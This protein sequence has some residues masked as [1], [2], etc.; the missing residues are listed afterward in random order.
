MMKQL[1]TLLMMLVLLAFTAPGQ[2]TDRAQ[3]VDT[4]PV[5]TFLQSPG[6]DPEAT[7]IY[8]YD[9]NSGKAIA[10]HNASKPLVPASVM[11]CVTTASLLDRAGRKWRYETPVYITGN[12]RKGVLDG[13][14]L[15]EASADPSV[16]TR[17]DPG[18]DNI[19]DE[20]VQALRQ[21]HIDT[22]RGSIV[23]DEHRFAGPAINP[24]WASGDLPNAYG[25]GTHGFNFE[26]NASGNASVRD[27]GA[28]FRSRLTDALKA[29]GIT[30]LG[31]DIPND[32]RRRLI[33][34]HRSAEVQD[35]MRSC[36]MRS[37][38]QYAEAML[39]TFSHLKGRDGSTA[40]GADEEI[41][42]WK[43]KGAPLKDVRIVDGSGLSRSNRLTADF[44]GSV[45]GKMAHDPWYASFFP[46]AGQE[47]TLKRFMC[48]SRLEGYVALKTG[49]MNGI[50]SYAGYKINEDYA[51]THV[52]VVMMNNLK[53]R[54][55]ART[56][57]QTML[58]RLF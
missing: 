32:T 30:V 45:L 19:I 26:D 34:T 35:I 54:A 50:Q 56:D 28:R 53:N 52:V 42:L 37:D 18:S 17:H 57:L 27:P 5:A 1:N 41:K 9:L 47:G 29:N 36:M 2:N 43:H 49:S 16:N 8:I 44:L 4:D 15:V 48:G 12:T 23:V 58:E 22:V 51:P 38:N 25:T 13:N 24:T 55:R 21:E 10:T 39:R 3:A 46:L 20:I 11:K 33:G 6:I 7:S 40:S 31:R 14:I